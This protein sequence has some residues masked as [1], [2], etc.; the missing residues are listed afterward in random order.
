VGCLP[1]QGDGEVP[2]GIRLPPQSAGAAT[3]RPSMSARHRTDVVM[4]STGAAAE[5]LAYYLD[6]MSD[7]NVVGFA[8]DRAFQTGPEF[9]GRPVTAWEDLPTRFPPDEVRLIGPPTYARMNTYRRDRYLEGKAR[10]Y[11]FASYIHPGSMVMSD[12][13]GDHCVIL[14]GVTVLPRT[15]IGDN[16]VI[17]CD[18]HVGHH[19]EIGAHTFLSAQVGIAGST[20]IGEEC[21]LAGKVGVTNGRRIGERCAIMNA[22]L[23]KD[24]VPK[25]SVVVGPDAVVKSYPSERIKRLL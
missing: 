20:V 21:Y 8:V 15:R 23:V 3:R 1:P 7:L 24:D 5:V 9:L 13:I 11:A 22:A 14:H 4:I 18:T 10:G 16:V 19:C 25:D 6:H 2:R 12:D 17:W